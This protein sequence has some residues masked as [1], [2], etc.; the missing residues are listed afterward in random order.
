MA[1]LFCS[2]TRWTSLW[3]R[4]KTDI[5]WLVSIRLLI[6]LVLIAVRCWG[7]SMKGLMRRHRSTKKGS[8]SLR[9][10]KLWRRIGNQCGLSLFS[11]QFCYVLLQVYQCFV[12]FILYRNFSAIWESSLFFAVHSPPCWNWKVVNG[13]IVLMMF[14]N[15]SSMTFSWLFRIDKFNNLLLEANGSRYQEKLI[16]AQLS[17]Y[18]VSEKIILK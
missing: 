4:K 16:T 18:P 12:P 8:S 11:S 10:P 17:W 6:S 2:P 1:E 13:M 7:G 9:S 14:W 5:S 15:F 3:G